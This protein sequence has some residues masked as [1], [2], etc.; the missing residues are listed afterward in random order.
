LVLIG[1]GQLLGADYW[2]TERPIIGQC[3]ISASLVEN[4][5]TPFY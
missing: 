2:P 4:L 3:I 5:L 1:I